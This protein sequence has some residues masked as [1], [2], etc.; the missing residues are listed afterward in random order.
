[1][2]AVQE[3]SIVTL[4]VAAIGAMAGIVSALLSRSVRSEVRSQNGTTTGKLVTKLAD[5]VLEM[6][7]KLDGVTVQVA[8]IRMT[9][10]Q[11]LEEV[12]GT[13]AEGGRTP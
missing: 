6:D 13:G 3:Q 12:R 11:H 10:A 9:L 7:D 2:L 1:V 8:E 5:K 4:A